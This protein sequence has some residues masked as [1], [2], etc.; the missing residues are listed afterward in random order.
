MVKEALF[1]SLVSAL[2]NWLVPKQK[3]YETKNK[4]ALIAE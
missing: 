2:L 3:A 4:E 1:G